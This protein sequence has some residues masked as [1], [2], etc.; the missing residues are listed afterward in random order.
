MLQLEISVTANYT[1]E[2]KHY[3]IRVEGPDCENKISVVQRAE[4]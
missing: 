4:Q 1:K 3:E 2:S